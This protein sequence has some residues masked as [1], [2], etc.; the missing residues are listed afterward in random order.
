MPDRDRIIGDFKPIP[1]DGL[2]MPVAWMSVVSIDGKSESRCV[3]TL[4]DTGAS[5]NIVSI[6]L[7]KDLLKKTEEEIKKGKFLNLGGLGS[8]TRSYGWPINLRLRAKYGDTESVLIPDTWIYASEK[9]LSSFPVLFGQLGGFHKR[10][11]GH[12]NHDSKR[13]WQLVL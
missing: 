13:F 7:A 9:S 3:E 1:I 12:S 8:V 10:W 4:L 6:G 5:V 2:Y 11:F